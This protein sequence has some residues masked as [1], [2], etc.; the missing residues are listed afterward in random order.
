MAIFRASGCG[1]N[2]GTRTPGLLFTKQLLYQLSYVGL[3]SVRVTTQCM[4]LAESRA[5]VKST[6]QNVETL[7]RAT[8]SG[9]AIDC[10]AFSA[11]YPML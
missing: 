2:A 5:A 7:K 6:H 4:I 3:V 10:T 8:L 9:I 11:A 1:A